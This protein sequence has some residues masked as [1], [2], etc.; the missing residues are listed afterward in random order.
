MDFPQL[1]KNSIDLFVGRRCEPKPGEKHGPHAALHRR[2]HGNFFFFFITLGLD[3][4][5][6]KSTS[7]KYEPS[8]E[9]LLITYMVITRLRSQVSL[10]R[11][12]KR[13][14]TTFAPHKTLQSIA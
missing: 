3:L 9:L 2:L 13:N 4:S 1:Q 11:I 5:D 6:K 8:S 14:V 10:V 7:L 12:S